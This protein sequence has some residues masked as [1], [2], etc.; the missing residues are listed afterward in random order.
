MNRLKSISMQHGFF[1]I[2]VAMAMLA[3]AGVTEVVVGEY[4]GSIGQSNQAR[5]AATSMKETDQKR[6]QQGLE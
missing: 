4:A 3:V 1:S 6:N 2:A 5:Q